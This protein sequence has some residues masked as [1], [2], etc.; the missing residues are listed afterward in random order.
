MPPTDPVLAGGTYTPPSPTAPTPAGGSYSAPSATA[1]TPAGGSYSAPSA[2]A[3]VQAG[4]S[5][6]QPTL[7]VAATATVV[8]EAKAESVYFYLYIND[9][10]LGTVFG[11]DGLGD[12]TLFPA[13]MEARL[14]E[15]PYYRKRFALQRTSMTPSAG[16]AIKEEW[17]FT[18]RLSGE[19]PG[20]AAHSLEIVYPTDVLARYLV[21]GDTGFS[22][23]EDGTLQRPVLAGGVYDG[24]D[25]NPDDTVAPSGN[26]TPP[27]PTAPVAP[28]A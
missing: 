21:S 12:L 6:E 11:W 23:G 7:G 19:Y 25:I 8:F 2:T 18:A 1:P 14:N 20:T 27:S 16:Y 17:T 10:V 26:Y 9:P 3:P 28:G 5:Y 13:A 4:G 22:G 24:S 15:N